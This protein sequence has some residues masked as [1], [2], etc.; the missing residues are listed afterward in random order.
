MDN[1]VRNVESPPH[2]DYDVSF[3]QTVNKPQRGDSFHNLEPSKISN[4]DSSTPPT[5]DI[6]ILT[7]A[8]SPGALAHLY[9]ASLGNLVEIAFTS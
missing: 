5:D 1:K 9:G 4:S 2:S 8:M 6:A 7:Q 3:A